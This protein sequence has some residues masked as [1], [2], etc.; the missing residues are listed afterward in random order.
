MDIFD[1]FKTTAPLV[2]FAMDEGAVY[3][4]TT[5]NIT[6]SVQCLYLEEHSSPREEYYVWAYHVGIQNDGQDVVTL[7]S[8]C[9]TITDSRGKIRTVMGEGVIGEQPVLSPGEL[10][11]YTSGVP[12]TTPS[13]IM[14]GHYQMTSA[15]KK[16]HFK[17]QIPPFSLDS[18]YQSIVIN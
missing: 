8:R 12:L 4:L 1:K 9:W 18:P 10:F 15:G 17:V 13:G 14:V 2:T 11:E 5:H 3:K 16:E 7:K 6:V